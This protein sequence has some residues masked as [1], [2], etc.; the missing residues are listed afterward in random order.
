M[1]VRLARLPRVASRTGLRCQF[2]TAAPRRCGAVRSAAA[3]AGA[4]ATAAGLLAAAATLHQGSTAVVAAA[5]MTHNVPLADRHRVVL[6]QWPALEDPENGITTI[7]SVFEWA[8]RHGYDAL[9]FSV[10]DFKKKFMPHAPVA[11]VVSRV[12]A[13][14]ARYNMPT[15]G[16]LYHVPGEPHGAAAS[17]LLLPISDAT[18]L[19]SCP[20]LIDLTNAS[21]GVRWGHAGDGQA[22]PR[23]WQPFRPLSIGRRGLLPSAAREA[24]A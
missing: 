8:V 5:G 13:C 12:Q 17:G 16:A 10:D 23:G 15:I 1:L 14:V 7:D 18:T 11:E 4:A 9:E 20:A 19:P 3:A 21:Y 2:S 22:C 6:T 24:P